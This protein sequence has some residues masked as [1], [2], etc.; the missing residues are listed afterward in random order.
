MDPLAVL[1]L[2]EDATPDEVTAA[3]R[4]AAKQWH[5]DRHG[6]SRQAVERMAEV[7][8]AYDTLRAAAEAPPPRARAA[9]PGSRTPPGAWLP[10]AVRVA[11]GPE[12]LD[13][14]HPGEQVTVVTPASTWASPRT[15][16]AL[17]DKRLLWLADD[18]VLARVRSLPLAAIAETSIRTRRLG[19]TA[20]LRVQPLAGRRLSFAG[21]RPP[22]AE[23]LAREVAAVAAA[24]E[25]RRRAVLRR[26]GLPG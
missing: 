6:G 17:T 16:L 24:A 3:Y 20:E 15:V 12:L 9:G 4:R 14:L 7:N 13:A 11:L 26:A 19:G 2:A 5:P 10:A 18:A 25:Q 1:G 21:L 23:L 8:L 22:T